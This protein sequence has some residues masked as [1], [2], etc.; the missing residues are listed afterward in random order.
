MHDVRLPRPHDPDQRDQRHA[1]VADEVADA[2]RR[3]DRREVLRIGDVR[4]V[5]DVAR[6]AVERFARTDTSV[7]GQ[8]LKIVSANPDAM[9]WRFFDRPTR[10]GEL[11]SVMAVPNAIAQNYPVRPIRFLVTSPPGGANDT[12][13][14]V[15]GAKLVFSNPA[16]STA[17]NPAAL[18]S[19][20]RCNSSAV[21]T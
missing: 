5:E 16:A 7:T 14:R 3:L 13:A 15:L 19:P 4:A 21:C 2:D 10:A 18:S 9:R 8:A 17:C 1:E 12:Q 6:V 20:A 11:G